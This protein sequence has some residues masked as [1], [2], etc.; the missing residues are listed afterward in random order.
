MNTFSKAFHLSGNSLTSQ[1]VMTLILHSDKY[2]QESFLLLVSL[3]GPDYECR[4]GRGSI[5]MEFVLTQ[6]PSA[7]RKEEEGAPPPRSGM[8]GQAT[9][10]GRRPL[11]CLP[12]SQSSGRRRQKEAEEE[13]RRK[14]LPVRPIV[15]TE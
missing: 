4:P 14:R 2:Q 6:R 9:T 13:A 10:G 3:S 15:R 8:E 7:E 1:D 12:Q 5:I 11:Q